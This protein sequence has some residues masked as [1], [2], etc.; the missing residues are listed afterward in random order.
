VNLVKISSLFHRL[1][2]TYPDEVVCNFA[3]DYKSVIR[4][5]ER[6]IVMKHLF[7]LRQLKA[8]LS[9]ASQRIVQSVRRDLF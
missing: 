1:I 8:Q 7:S 6:S 9:A 2:S 4:H 3:A 5:Q